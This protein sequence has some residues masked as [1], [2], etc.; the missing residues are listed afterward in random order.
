MVQSSIAKQTNPLSVYSLTTSPKGSVVI[1]HH[2]HLLPLQSSAQVAVGVESKSSVSLFSLPDSFASIAV[3]ILLS[4]FS[5]VVQGRISQSAFA[6]LAIAW[7]SLSP[8]PFLFLQS[9]QC[10]RLTSTE[11]SMSL[12]LSLIASLTMSS[13][14]MERTAESISDSTSFDMSKLSTAD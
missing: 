12:T 5:W 2:D 6:G 13:T 4:C 14:S 7:R 8:H 3:I 1:L 9:W 10:Q 11:I